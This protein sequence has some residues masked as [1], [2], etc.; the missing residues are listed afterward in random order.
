MP[1][2]WHYKTLTSKKRIM[3]M[4]DPYNSIAGASLDETLLRFA[5]NR[6]KVTVFASGT[7]AAGVSANGKPIP[8][9]NRN[10]ARYGTPR[11]GDSETLDGGSSGD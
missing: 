3:G 1:L 10:R 6:A 2:A 5:E 8:R 4:N 11:E 9:W 7:G